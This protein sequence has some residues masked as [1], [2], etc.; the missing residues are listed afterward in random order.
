MHA[1]YIK[2]LGLLIC[3]AIF[4]LEAS[5]ASAGPDLKQIVTKP[6]RM[7]IHKFVDHI[8]PNTTATYRIYDFFTVGA[9]S[10]IHVQADDADGSWVGGNDD[11]LGQGRKSCVTIQPIP[12]ART[13]HVL[14]RSYSEET[15]GVGAFGAWHNVIVHGVSCG[16]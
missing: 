2:R 12:T 9:D 8:P 10:V 7:G 13:V 1:N 16:A 11:C 3:S 15:H 5:E 6:Q 14:V 4:L